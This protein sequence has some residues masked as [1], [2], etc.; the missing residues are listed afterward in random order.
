MAEKTQ[1]SLIQK[2]PRVCGGLARIRETRIPVWTLVS[3][4]RQDAS[5]Q[6]L[7]HNY[8][9]LNQQDL[10]AAWSYYAQHPE[11]IDQVI[12]ELNDGDD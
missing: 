6:E 8:P 1:T 9:G 4:R 11:E 2:T 12:A 3:F 5:D 10:E 7:L